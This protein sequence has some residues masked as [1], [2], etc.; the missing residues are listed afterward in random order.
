MELKIRAVRIAKGIR[1][2]DLAEAMG[3]TDSVVVRAENGHSK[4]T[5]RQI[6]I[7]RE[8][9]DIEKAPLL[10]EELVIFKR[11]LYMWRDLI[12]DEHMEEAWKAQ[13]EMSIITQLPFEKDLIMLYNM[14]EVRLLLKERRFDEAESR[15]K[16]VKPELENAT[17][18]N[19][20]HYYYNMGSLHLFRRNHEDA[21]LSY[22]LANNMEIDGFEKESFLLY[23]LAICYARLGKY[24]LSIV[25]MEQI[26]GQHRDYKQGAPSLLFDNNLGLNYLRIGHYERAKE[27]FNNVLINAKTINRTVYVGFA[28][29]NM[30]CVCFRLGDYKKANKYFDDAFE[31]ISSESSCYLE[32]L[33]YKIRCQIAMKVRGSS[34]YK[35]DLPRAILMAEGNEHYTLLFNSLAHTKTFRE[36]ASQD[37]I[38]NTTIPYFLQRYEY[39]KALDFCEI[40]EIAFEKCYLTKRVLEIKVMAFDIHKKMTSGRDY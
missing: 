21:L 38:E 6:E 15:L 37:Y 12:K 17:K 26:S 31:Y 33:Y 40:L 5:N 39:S 36:K 18:E 1:Q 10:D 7:A 27:L 23:N 4:Y 14:L 16:L 35:I 28:L 32:N 29:H 30:G 25:M 24:V 3:L 8:F 11:R 22:T 2:V 34:V 13:Q 19:Q 9:L 20:Y